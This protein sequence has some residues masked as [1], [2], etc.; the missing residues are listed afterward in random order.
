MSKATLFFEE[1]SNHSSNTIY[2]CMLGEIVSFNSSNRICS[3]KPVTKNI[4]RGQQFEFDI[5]QGV[6][7]TSFRVGGFVI[8]MPLNVGDRVIILFS[9]YDI[10]NYLLSGR[11]VDN[12]T[13]S[14]HSLDDAIVIPLS[15]T[16]STETLTNNLNDLVIAK[17][18]F[19]S[20]IVLKPNGEIEITSDSTMNINTGNNN[21]NIT[22]T[23][24][25]NVE[26]D[27]YEFNV[28]ERNP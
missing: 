9:D 10:S 20:K 14:F 26:I 24:Q 16:L 23:G 25:G 28:T 11:I 4:I 27:C 1:F 5:L 19:S 12:N 6:P 17:N 21:L 7:A 13:N 3:V 18:D 22:T 15:T 8:S 2:S